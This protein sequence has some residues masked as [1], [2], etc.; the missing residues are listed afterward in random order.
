MPDPVADPEELRRRVYGAGATEADVARY[1]S[2]LVAHAGQGEPSG[3]GPGAGRADAPAASGRRGA[4][5]GTPRPPARRALLTV[6][7]VAVL[8]GAIV[9]VQ[10]LLHPAPSAP[11]PVLMPL[12]A[13]E[14][15]GFVRELR[16]G[17]AAGIG[18]HL[19]THPGPAAIRSATY[20][21]T[22]EARGTG[23]GSLRVD[24]E[25]LRDL[26]RRA[27]VLIVLDA[28]ADVRWRAQGLGTIP[29]GAV[30]L[31]TLRAGS[32]HQEAGQ[33]STATFRFRDTDRPARLRVTVPAGVRWGAAVVLSD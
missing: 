26:H 15:A 29:G 6:L 28:A 23:S 5:G 10:P 8:A 17:F 2:A 16:D 7:V 3:D 1:R 32:A 25:M 31:H 20:F 19:V 33:L 30:T 4:R 21:D 22:V 24:P 27:T 12:T 13:A 18:D 11:A 14:R 9:A